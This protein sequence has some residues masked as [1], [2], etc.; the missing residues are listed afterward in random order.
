M[1]FF[2]SAHKNKNELL[3]SQIRKIMSLQAEIFLPT[4]I[5]GARVSE[6]WIHDISKDLREIRGIPG[7]VFTNFC[8]ISQIFF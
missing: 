2:P 6:M 4:S 7:Y 5:K 1:T 3:H 8:N